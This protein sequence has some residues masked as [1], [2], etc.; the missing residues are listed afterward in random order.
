MDE[1][2]VPGENH[3]PVV[4]HVTNFI[5]DIA[6]ILLKLALNTNQLKQT[7]SHDAVSS[8][9]LLGRFRTHNVSIIDQIKII[10]S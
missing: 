2:G 1:K 4:S 3:R 8:T 7:L 9:P 6:E 5:Y 10:L